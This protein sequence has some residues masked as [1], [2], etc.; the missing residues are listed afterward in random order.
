MSQQAITDESDWQGWL[1]T[2]SARLHGRAPD[3]MAALLSGL[4]Q[5]VF[6]LPEAS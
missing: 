1:V 3:G 2:T 5:D 4:H 6:E